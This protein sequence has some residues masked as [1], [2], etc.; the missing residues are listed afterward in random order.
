MALRRSSGQSPHSEPFELFPEFRRH[1][2]FDPILDHDERIDGQA[3]GPSPNEN[4]R[5]ARVGNEAVAPIQGN[6][7]R[8]IHKSRLTL[9]LHKKNSH[10]NVCGLLTCSLMGDRDRTKQDRI[11]SAQK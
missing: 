6:D 11:A 1:S 9:S 8:V 7:M 4:S 10:G 5:H 2:L 3:S